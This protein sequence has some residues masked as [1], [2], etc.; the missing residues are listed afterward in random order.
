MATFSE[1]LGKLPNGPFLEV[2]SNLQSIDEINELCQQ[3]GRCDSQF[4]KELILRQ[5][6]ISIDNA[7]SED[8]RVMYD[9]YSIPLGI[10]TDYGLN[11][12]FDSTLVE[13]RNIEVAALLDG[14]EYK[15]YTYN[16]EFFHTHRDENL[17]DLEGVFFPAHTLEGA[18]LRAFNYLHQMNGHNLLYDIF[19]NSYIEVTSQS[20]D[21]FMNGAGLIAQDV[22]YNNL[23]DRIN[24]YLQEGLEPEVG[25]DAFYITYVPQINLV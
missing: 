1:R 4:W 7:T 11:N 15:Y 3:T 6:G 25:K 17:A 21:D 10:F 12:L 9:L 16:P 8:H 22:D 14:D 19:F 23:L 2:A 24:T 13:M 5:T 18:A 20:V